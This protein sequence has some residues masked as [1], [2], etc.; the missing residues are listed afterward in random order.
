M[1]STVLKI[2]VVVISLER[3]FKIV[4]AIIHRKYYRNWMTTVGVAVPW[5]TG[6]CTFAIPAI[7]STRNVPGQCPVIG[8]W[9]TEVAQIVRMYFHFNR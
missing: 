7:I 3:Y 6:F 5:I 2:G 8:V 1:L 9:S 4:H